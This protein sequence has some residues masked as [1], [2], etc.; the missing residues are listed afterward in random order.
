MPQRY[1]RREVQRI[2]GLDGTPP[3]AGWE[4]LRLV[5]SAANTVLG[6]S[7]LQF[8]RHS[9]RT[10]TIQRITQQ[11]IPARRLRRAV[12]LVEQQFSGSALPLQELQVLDQG[13]EVLV[14]PPGANGKP[15]LSTPSASSGWFPF[16][17]LQASRKIACHV[18]QDSL[19]NGSTS[20]LACEARVELL[21][22]NQSRD[23][24]A[25][26]SSR[27]IGSKRI[28]TWA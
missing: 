17:V 26:S 24:A 12:S 25:R 23:T 1:T 7:L 15:F 6:E 9:S 16:G 21:S 5:C 11:K 3:S 22:R 14:V 10:S 20:R 19:S 4:R 27:P 13:R 2:L 18:E 28:S 8:W